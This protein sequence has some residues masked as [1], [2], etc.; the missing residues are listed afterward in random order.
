M[1]SELEITGSPSLTFAANMNFSEFYK[2]M[3]DNI[4]NTGDNE[5]KI[6]NCTSPSLQYKTFLSYMKVYDDDYHVELE[7]E[8]DESISVGENGHIII[9]GIEIPIT[10]DDIEDAG[11]NIKFNELDKDYPISSSEDN[12][13]TAS[14]SGLEEYL[15]GFGFY[16]VQLKIF[17]YMDDSPLLNCLKVEIFDESSGS[18]ERLDYRHA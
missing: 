18:P 9:N 13:I 2:D 1:P 14:F 16:T 8:N 11:E 17:M 5:I 3:F 7:F 10:I 15:S 4:L 12:P 6:L